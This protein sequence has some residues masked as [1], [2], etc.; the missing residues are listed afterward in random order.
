[1][2][3]RDEIYF[4]CHDCGERILT[5][6]GKLLTESQDHPLRPLRSILEYQEKIAGRRMCRKCAKRFA[7]IVKIRNKQTL[8]RLV[9]W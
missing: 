3:T 4:R 8:E 1:M 2:K 7:K 5:D 6:A 9:P